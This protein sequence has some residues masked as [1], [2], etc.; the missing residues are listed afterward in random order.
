MVRTGFHWEAH[1]C[2]PCL[3]LSSRLAWAGHKGLSRVPGEPVEVHSSPGVNPSSSFKS[4]WLMQVSE[5]RKQRLPLSARSWREDSIEQDRVQEGWKTVAA[6]LMGL[7]V[8]SPSPSLG[9]CDVSGKP[10]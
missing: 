8:K 1:L 2:S 9:F 5:R 4:Y 3:L 7:V 6:S 10:E